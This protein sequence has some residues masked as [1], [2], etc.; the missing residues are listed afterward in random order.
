MKRSFRY[1]WQFT[2]VNLMVIAAFA[3]VL[4]V[5]TVVV[6]GETNPQPGAGNMVATYFGMFPLMAVIIVFLL[7]TNLS[8]INLDMAVSMGGRRQDYFRGMQVAFAAYALTCWGLSLVLTRIPGWLNWPDPEQWR[9]LLSLGNQPW[10]WYPLICMTAAAAGA[11][12]GMLLVRHKVLAVFF[13][14]AAALL[15]VA[16]VVFL[17]LSTFNSIYLWGDMHRI[18][19]GLLAAVLV[20]CEGVLWRYIKGYCVR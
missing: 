1:L 13:L 17:M 19:P 6:G 10:W 9:M 20:I 2:A 11:V 15:G 3:A 14:A 16:S 5:L 12:C 7:A 8:T 18:I 4:P